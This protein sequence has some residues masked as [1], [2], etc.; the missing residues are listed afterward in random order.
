M[1]IYIYMYTYVYTCISDA[2]FGGVWVQQ[3]FHGQ[4]RS[5]RLRQKLQPC[6]GQRRFRI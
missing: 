6:P 4:G 5:T 3:E 2:V 1:Y